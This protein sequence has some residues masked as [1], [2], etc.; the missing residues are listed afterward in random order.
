MQVYE[1]LGLRKIIEE[2]GNHISSMNITKANLHLRT[3]VDF[4][5]FWEKT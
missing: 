2:N 4:I 1:K 5:L 3:N